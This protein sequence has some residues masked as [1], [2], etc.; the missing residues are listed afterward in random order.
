MA[1]FIAKSPQYRSRE[2]VPRSIGVRY[3]DLRPSR[4][5]NEAISNLGNLLQ[6][7]AE[8]MKQE[9]DTAVVGEL[10]NTWRDADRQALS[11]LFKKKG[12]DAVNLGEEYDK[13]FTKSQGAADK[14]AENGSQQAQLNNMLSRRR[15]QNLDILAKYQVVEY[16]ESSRMSNH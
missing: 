14:E 9:R 16:Q 10:Y 3:S 6:V 13:F 2:N 7:R 15:E 8:E 11:E 4:A 12:K 5:E 1:L